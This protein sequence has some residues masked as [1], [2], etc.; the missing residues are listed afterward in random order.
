MCESSHLLVH[1]ISNVLSCCK[2]STMY[3]C[4]NLG[5]EIKVTGRISPLENGYFDVSAHLDTRY[6][7]L[8]RHSPTDWFHSFAVLL[9]TITDPSVVLHAHYACRTST[10]HI[11]VCDSFI[12][13]QEKIFAMTYAPILVYIYI[14]SS[15]PKVADS[16]L[17]QVGGFS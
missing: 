1:I 9:P 4:L 10:R 15:A 6:F 16:T 8:T 17:V 2:P 12:Y 3:W 13:L 7:N 14:L 11:Y 5:N